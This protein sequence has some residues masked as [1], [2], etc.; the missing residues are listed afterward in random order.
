MPAVEPVTSAC[1]PASP[2][3]I[4]PSRVLP[5]VVDHLAVVGQAAGLGELDL[6]T[7][8]A[9]GADG[10]FHR[11]LEVGRRRWRLD[12]ESHDVGLV[13]PVDAQAQAAQTGMLLGNLGDLLGI[14]EHA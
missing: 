11:L 14:D 10:A 1:L 5:D 8:L 9:D 4:A 6:A 13:D 7:H 2:S 3:S 12:L